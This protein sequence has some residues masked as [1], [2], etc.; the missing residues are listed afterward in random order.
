MWY[1]FQGLYCVAC[2]NFRS[3]PF[4]DEVS[5]VLGGGL[6]P[7]SFQFLNYIDTP[8]T[9]Y[10]EFFFLFFFPFCSAGIKNF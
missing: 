6:V 3:G 4:G 5:R 7:G 9:I 8:A 2:F 10:S 1:L